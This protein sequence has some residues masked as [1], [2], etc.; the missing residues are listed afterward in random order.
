MLRWQLRVIP[1]LLGAFLLLPRLAFAQTAVDV[2]TG[3]DNITRVGIIFANI[4]DSAPPEDKTKDD[5]QCRATGQCSLA[6]VLQIFVNLSIFLLG[7]CGS[8]ALVMFFYGGWNWVFAQGRPEY[9]QAGKDTMKH[10]IIGLAIIFGAY[11]AINLV[12]AILGGI[13]PGTSIEETINN[14]DV[15]KNGEDVDINAD[16]VLNSQ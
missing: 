2:G 9:I 11:S 1:F 12:I 6:N 13:D 3:Y 16:S 15:E 8:I 4:C 10:A 14:L 7:I 5:C